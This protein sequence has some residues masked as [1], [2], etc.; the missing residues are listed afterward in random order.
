[1]SYLGKNSNGETY[2]RNGT[3]KKKFYKKRWFKIAIPLIII[4][5]IVGGIFAFKTDSILKRIS[6]SGLLSVLA[7]SIPGVSNELKGEKDGRINV[8]LLGMRGANDPAGGLLS[9]T[10]QVLSI[11]PKAN[12]ASLISIPRDL[13][14]DNPA[15][16][17]KTK[18]NAVH[19]YG[20]Q[21]GS[22]QGMAYMEQVVGSITG[23]PIQYA[24][25]T[26]F[27]GFKKTIDAIGGIQI[28]LDQP[29]DESVQFNQPHVCDSFFTVPTG[30]FDTKTKNIYWSGTK[31]LKKVKT[32]ASYP[33]CTAPADTLECG[34]D[35]TLPAGT[36]TLNA[37]QA[38]C[39]ARSRETSNDFERAKRQQQ[40]IQAVK[41]KLLSLGTLTD[42]GKVNNIINSLGDNVKTDMQSWEMKRFYDLYNQMKGYQMYNRVIDGSDDPEVGLVYGQKDPTFGDILLPKGDNFDKF[43]ALFQNIFTMSPEQKSSTTGAAGSN[44]AA[45]PA[46]GSASNSSSKPSAN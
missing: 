46:S 36:Q 16:G 44:A 17:Y 38:L 6:K 1:M 33:L 39:Y 29:F 35:F 7:H 18:I 9:D 11:E 14:V 27:D 10:I 45:N 15:V 20:E 12:K 34:G 2:K 21:K 43:K 37:S 42:F 26:N 32:V 13:F 41:D 31:T 30:K 24:I 25:T 5:L 19:A 23:L 3:V 40:V 22:G 4:L 8:L 28:T